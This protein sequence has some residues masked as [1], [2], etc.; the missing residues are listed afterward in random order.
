MMFQLL[1]GSVLT[2]AS[3]TGGAVLWWGLKEI[4]GLIEPWL[5]RPPDVLKTLFVIAMIVLAAMTMM[6]LG[7]W[8]WAAVLLRVSAF[9]SVEEAVYFALVAYT[10]L[11]LGDVSVPT[12][13]RLLGGM[14]GANGFLMF[15]LMTATLTD[16]LRYVRSIQS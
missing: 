6:T 2:F 4:I 5:T 9:G 15:G 11:G 7:I 1:L 14:I 3:V 10:T 13:Y 16:S 8:F 12:E